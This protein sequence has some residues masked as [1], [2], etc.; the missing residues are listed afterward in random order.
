ML[1]LIY[2]VREVP[3]SIRVLSGLEQIVFCCRGGWEKRGVRLGGQ[4]REMDKQR[5][6]ASIHMPFVLHMPF[7]YIHKRVRSRCLWISKSTDYCEDTRKQ[8]CAHILMILLKHCYSILIY[9][10]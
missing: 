5:R 7:G 4:C 8:T 2:R 6:D 10:T 1:R 3:P 9:L